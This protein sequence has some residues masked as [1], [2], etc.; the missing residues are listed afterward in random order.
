MP[1]DCLF[2]LYEICWV[3]LKEQ[4]NGEE[5]VEIRLMKNVHARGC[6]KGTCTISRWILLIFQNIVF[7]ETH[8]SLD[9]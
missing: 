6:F 1:L 2:L 7:P 3:N 9:Y 4:K 5:L 8:K